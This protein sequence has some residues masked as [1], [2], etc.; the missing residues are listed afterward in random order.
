MRGLT[1]AAVLAVLLAGIGA[2]PAAKAAPAAPPAPASAEYAARPGGR[3]VR[4]DAPD[5]V[6]VPAVHSATTVQACAALAPQLLTP[7]NGATS[8]D[9][10]NPRFTW[11]RV[12]GVSEF[13]F[14]LA[15]NSSFTN[16]LATESSGTPAH[17]G[18]VAH[19]TFA[20]LDPLSTYYWRVASVCADGQIGA[21]SAGFVL[22]AGAGAGNVSCTLPPPALLAPANNAQVNTL[23]PQIAWQRAP[24][25]YEYYYQLASDSGFSNV[26]DSSYFIGVD[27]ELNANVSTRPLDNLAPNTRYYWRVLSI[28]ASIDKAGSF[29]ATFSFRT[30]ADT[31]ALPPAP[32]QIAPE[33]GVTTGSIRLTILY[34]AVGQAEQ[35]NVRLYETRTDAEQDNWRSA[36]SPF[37]TVAVLVRQPEQTFFW[38]VKARNAFGWGPLSGIRSFRTP[39]LT[40]S[41]TITPQAGGTLSPSGGFL[42]VN[43]PAGAVSAPTLLDYL[44]QPSPQHSLPGYR[45]ANR[46][47]TLNAT[48]NGQPLHQFNKPF[49]M[50][51]RYDPSDLLAAGISNPATLNM[52]YWNGQGWQALLPCAGCGVD[53]AQRTVTVVLNHLSEFALVAPGAANVGGRRV[54]VPLARR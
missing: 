44:L 42:T 53:T 4:A 14:Q 21:F 23:I 28:C 52:V 24:N 43:F 27:P 10:Q 45:F 15:A 51:V 13:V 50:L 36:Y 9:L 20:D 35:Y 39:A 31:S 29:G 7:A 49:T 18:P 32:Q 25:T 54:F 5:R 22:H 48:S 41:A 6:A 26:V 47:F 34:S 8:N 19:T 46:A 37:G 38:R 11:N 17:P 1:I 30:P 40:A 2:A 3:V 16:L 12:A 33:D